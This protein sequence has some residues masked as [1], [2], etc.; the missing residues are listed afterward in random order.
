M[1]N[2][3][4][5]RAGRL[6]Q[7]VSKIGTTPR[8]DLAYAY[9][10]GG[11]VT[12]I[13]DT[14]RGETSAFTYDMLDRLLTSSVSVSGV[15]LV[16]QESY[17][18]YETG[19]IRS[20]TRWPQTTHLG[21]GAAGSG[22]VAANTTRGG[23][24]GLSGGA[25][26]L[27][28]VRGGEVEQP[29]GGAWVSASYYYSD[30]EHV[31]AATGLSSGATFDYDDNGNM[32][33]RVEGGRVYTQ[34]FDAENRLVSVAQAG[35]GTTTYVYDGDGQLTKQV[36]PNGTGTL[37]LGVVE[38]ELNPNGTTAGSTSYYAVPG[39][40]AVRTSAGLFYVLTDHLGS[41]SVSLDSGGNVAAEMRYDAFGATR[42]AIGS[43]PGDRLYTGQVWQQG[44]GLYYFN[45]RWYS[46]YTSGNITLARC[47]MSRGPAQ[48]MQLWQLARASACVDSR[49]V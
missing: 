33:G 4:D 2:T 39:A 13:V 11:N 1:A 41:A 43:M 6:I 20:V 27:A 29:L 30:S 49:G 3:Y 14:T 5:P 17:A 28:F 36:N 24:T 42:L 23:V 22:A 35:V 45:A 46:P 31:H 47:Q 38:Y 44:I 15:G 40:R 32:I 48:T 8:L 37:Y 9:D 21:Y 7:T 26:S 25:A 19:N 12:Q 34:T 16:R 10:L 18:Y